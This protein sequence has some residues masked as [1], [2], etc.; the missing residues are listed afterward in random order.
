MPYRP[1][2]RSWFVV[3]QTLRSRLV[4]WNTLVVLI[5][6]LAALYGVRE[7]L[8]FYLTS[9]IESVLNEEVKVA[10]L[11]VADVYPDRLQTIEQL[12]RIVDG[13]KVSDWHVRWLDVKRSRTIWASNNAPDFPLQQ[14]VRAG[15][16][17]TVWT[18]ESLL[19]V[20]RKLVQRDRPEF[21]LRIGT[22]LTF[23]TKDVD[24]LTVV[25]APVGLVLL[26]LAPLGGFL[27]AERAIEPLQNLI[28]LTERLRPSRMEERIPLRGVGDELDQLA[29][30]INQFLDQIADYIRRNRDFLANAA[31]E[32]RSP[33]TAIQSSVE[34]TLEKQRS[35]DEYEEL[36]YAIA[37]ECKHLS[38]L[39]NQ[40]LQLAESEAGVSD[41]AKVPVLLN[42]IVDRT[43]EMFGPVA[44]ERG[45]S[46]E[47]QCEPKVVAWGES[48]QLRQLVTNL[49]DNAIKFT[50]AGG[51]VTVALRSLVGDRAELR[52]QDTG[53]GIPAEDIPRVFERFYQVDR[54]R[55]R[56]VEQR[57]NGLGLSI[58]N[59]IIKNHNGTV[60]VVSRIGE[61]TTFTITLPER[62][63]QPDGSVAEV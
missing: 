25:L 63:P 40:L 33:L 57:G 3:F 10:L 37:D 14:L 50:P 53:A 20:E 32:L 11:A 17:Y 45:I 7:G 55:Q 13:H 38:I 5:T 39:V 28:R 44:E 34:V 16:D 54:S 62:P 46:L 22:P 36:L 12:Q 49:V 51:K 27:L 35:P 6:V 47:S 52:V 59:A 1:P 9:E 56:G 21:Y 23:I 18:S 4:F 42:E 61:G 26:L 8:R 31:H 48:R 2:E 24:R 29:F 15:P 30:K 19:S 58:C 60:G 41:L 43:V